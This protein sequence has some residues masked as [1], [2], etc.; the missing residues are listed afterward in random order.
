[1]RSI[2]VAPQAAAACET[3]DIGHHRAHVEPPRPMPAVT[4]ATKGLWVSGAL[5]RADLSD[6]RF[7]SCAWSARFRTSRVLLQPCVDPFGS[8]TND[9]AST[10]TCVPDL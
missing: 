1:M 4:R 3:L 6:A 10:D 2:L 7:S 5:E 8:Q 9:P